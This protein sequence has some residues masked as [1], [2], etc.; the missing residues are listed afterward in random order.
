MY[1]SEDLIERVRSGND[2]VDVISSYVKLKKMGTTYFGLCPFH[3]EKSPSFSVT[4]SKQMYYCF[5]CG[6]GGNVISFIMRYE[7]YS[8]LEATKMLADRAGI[9]LPQAEYSEEDRRRTELRET[10]LEINKKAAVYFHHQL[11]SEKGETGRKY[12]ENRGL[13]QETIKHFGLGYSNKMSDDL[14]RYMKSKGYTDE[15][16]KESGL[17]SFSEKGTYDKFW[18]RVMFP[19]LDLNSKVIGFGGRVLGEG[20]PKYLNSPETKIFEKSR[21]LY[22]MN[23][24]RLSRK[25]YL[26][27]CEGY[28][29]VIALHRAGFTNAVAA[30]GTAFTSQHAM[31]IKRYVDEVVLTFDSDGA[32]KKA[33]LRAIPI[34]KQ[35]GVSIRVLDMVP[36][37]DPD[38]FIKNLGAEEYQK[39]IDNAI[40]YFIFETRMMREEYDFNNPDAKAAFYEKVAKKLLE[41]PDELKRNVY[42]DA[43]AKEFQIP[44]DSLGRKVKTLALNYKGSQSSTPYDDG[45][46]T[47]ENREMKQK[48]PKG[49]D[50]VKQAQKLLLTWMV[51]DNNIYQKVRHLISEDDFIDPFYH[52]VAKLLFEQFE[53]GDNNPAKILNRFTQEEDHKKAAEIFNTSLTEGL[54][55]NEMEKALNE[56]VLKV[57]KNSLDYRFKNASDFTELQKILEEQKKLSK[58]Q[59]SL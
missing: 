56:M 21:N 53:A 4:P 8:F 6:E 7:N 17:F 40:S 43:V 27:I 9:D 42:V 52:N 29:D 46:S 32:G 10:L 59:I 45:S 11:M 18:N 35:V 3:N 20:E 19:I 47:M 50:G 48:R 24:A 15:V 26:L 28:M 12:F 23:F 33:A 25:P 54:S 16:L 30:L 31:L 57:K 34:L 14:Y 1:Y 13:N 5:G 2:I 41:F 49:E 39:R 44:V 58:I 36:Y 22:G 51:E 37:K 38:E 55:H